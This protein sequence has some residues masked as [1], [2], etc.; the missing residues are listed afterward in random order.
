M[1]S[2]SN[3]FE[4]NMDG[5]VA[6]DTVTPPVSPAG[7][8]GMSYAG[9]MHP[10][11]SQNYYSMNPYSQTNPN[12]IHGSV[13]MPVYYP[14]YPS[15][16]PPH[17][18]F[19]NSPQT[20]HQLQHQPSP[21][22]SHFPQFPSTPLSTN[23]STYS[24]LP[25][26]SPE[27]S[28]SSRESHP[29][30][31]PNVIANFEEASTSVPEKVDAVES[32]NVSV[33]SGSKKTTQKLVLEEVLDDLCSRF[34]LSL[35]E[36]EFDSFDRIF[37]AI[38]SAYWYYDDFYRE[39]DKSLPNM[40]WRDFAF[41]LFEHSPL[42]RAN[43]DD[44]EQLVSDFHAYK[45]EVPSCGCALVNAD[46]TK[47][48]LVLSW[49][50]KSRWGFPKG[51]LAKDELEI[52]CARRE[53]Y[54][55][56]GFDCEKLLVES[57][58]LDASVGSRKTRIYVVVGVN[59][60]YPFEPRTRKEI[61]KISWHPIASLPESV[62]DSN[63]NKMWGVLP[64]SKRLKA[65][66]ERKRKQ[67][68]K[69]SLSAHSSTTETQTGASQVSSK[70]QTPAKKTKKGS[71][72]TV[73]PS[74]RT[75]AGQSSSRKKDDITFGQGRSGGLSTDERNA[76]FESYLAK[77]EEQAEA[78]AE[79]DRLK[80][81]KEELRI[82][83]RNNLTFPSESAPLETRNDVGFVA[84]IFVDDDSTQDLPARTVSFSKRRS[85]NLGNGMENSLDPLLHFRFDFGPILSC[86]AV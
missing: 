2:S 82:N 14:Q 64:F 62:S 46:M 81:T 22:P 49:G 36:S 4:M 23:Q 38:E 72:T 40:K 37:F 66:V 73:T 12:Q 39:K 26:H 42:L 83:S 16:N 86:F 65:F 27:P 67:K 60:D 30:Q 80:E 35:P 74:T 57:D 77:V 78:E 75:L 7:P 8:Y 54:E 61:A 68:N 33:V 17:P 47:V 48:A 10:H 29:I 21:A 51:K 43:V 6:A 34:L 45:Q 63:G 28:Q 76:L 85:S 44:F 3:N 69:K 25:V 58:Y 5:L 79:K 11:S 32:E 56:T 1:D 18:H 52:E 31:K 70:R 24:Y 50:T 55:E 84:G 53:V 20:V 71:S 15:P 9:P 59:E 13:N 19:I 41:C